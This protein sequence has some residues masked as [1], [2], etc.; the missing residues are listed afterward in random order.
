LS[1]DNDKSE[2][3]EKISVLGDS[4]SSLNNKYFLINGPRNLNNYYVWYNVD[5]SGVDPNIANR[6]GIQVPISEGDSSAIVALATR[7]AMNLNSDFASEF[8]TKNLDDV[9]EL[10]AKITGSCVFTDFNTGFSFLEVYT[11]ITELVKEIELPYE[12]GLR[13]I[14]NSYKKTFEIFPIL[15][16]TTEIIWDEIQTTYPDSIT[17]V[18]T[19]KKDSSTVRVITV[20]YTSQSKKYIDSVIKT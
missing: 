12:D 8:V 9:V 15:T 18:F 4:S 20:V 13:Y 3:L 19:Y 16:T 10:T 17:E 7:L 14:Y 6:Q 11:G 1:K 2:Q 5:S